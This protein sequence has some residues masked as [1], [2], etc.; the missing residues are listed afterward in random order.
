MSKRF[1]KNSRD[2]AQMDDA[3][4]EKMQQGVLSG[5]AQAGIRIYVRNVKIT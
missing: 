5:I 3:A 4:A 1:R 2:A